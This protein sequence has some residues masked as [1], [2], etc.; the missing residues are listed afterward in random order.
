MDTKQLDEKLLRDEIITNHN[1]NMF[2]EAGAGA[3][4]T[5]LIVKKVANMLKDG[6]KPEEI[7]VITFTNAAVEELQSRIIAEVRKMAKDAK[8]DVKLKEILDNIDRMNISTIHSFC[9]LLLNEQS[10][11]AGLPQNIKVMKEPENKQLK[12]DYFKQYLRTLK[13]KDWNR[14]KEYASPEADKYN[15]QY[16]LFQ[17]YET[18][19]DLPTE[20]EIIIPPMTEKDEQERQLLEIQ[21]KIRDFLLGN[22]E[23]GIKGFA[24]E[25]KESVNDCL[26]PNKSKPNVVKTYAEL[27][28]IA[29]E[30]VGVKKE[31]I[32]IGKAVLN[33]E[34]IK[35]LS[36]LETEDGKKREDVDCVEVWAEIP[37]SNL[38]FVK[39]H[40]DPEYFDVDA[41]SEES[42]KV[43]DALQAL[44]NDIKEKYDIEGIH[45]IDELKD[46]FR[47]EVYYGILIEYA[48]KAKEDFWKNCPP[49][50]ISND[51]LL[52]MARDMICNND[53]IC[54]YFREKYKILFVDEF[55]DTDHVQAE[56][57][58][59]LASEPDPEN[60]EYIRLRDGALF[61]VGDPKQ[62]IYRFRG[63]EPENY[64]YI[65]NKMAGLKNA[66]IYELKYNFR[67][68]ISIINWVNGKFGQ[69]N[70]GTPIV[71]KNYNFLLMEKPP[72]EED[73]Q[74]QLT[75][76]NIL[77]GI[78]YHRSPDR[79]RTKG[80]S[81]KPIY[82]S[83]QEDVD[84]V[85]NL[86]LKLIG[87]GESEEK[88]SYKLYDDEIKSVRDIRC[89]DILLIS[90]ETK[91]MRR[92]VEAL[93]QYDIPVRLEGA[94]KINEDLVINTYLRIYKYLIEN[95]ERS[96]MGAMEA[97]R[98][99]MPEEEYDEQFKQMAK[100]I[101]ARLVEQSKDMTDYGKARYLEKQLSVL[102]TK[103]CAIAGIDV[104]TQQT[105]IRQMLEMIC[106]MEPTVGP[107]I[108]KR[109]EEY[110]K[111]RIER[112]LSLEQKADAVR[113]INLH[114]TK[115]LEGNIVILLDRRS[116]ALDK[117]VMYRQGKKIWLGINTWP[118]KQV[119][120]EQREQFEEESQAEF[121]RLE[122]VMATRAKQA[123][124]FMDVLEEKGLFA[125]DADGTW[126]SYEIEQDGVSLEEATKFTGLE[127]RKPQVEEN[128]Y[129]KIQEE[130]VVSDIGNIETCSEVNYI[131]VSPSGKEKTSETK[132][133]VIK[134]AIQ[135]IKQGEIAKP[136]V[137]SSLT[138]PTG[139]IM[140]NVLHRTME[141]FVNRFTPKMD[142]EQ[143]EEMISYCV[144]QAAVENKED[145]EKDSNS[146]QAQY[147]QFVMA[148]GKAYY[149]WFCQE[150]KMLLSQEYRTFTELPFQYSYEEN[151]RQIWVNGTADLVIQQGDEFILID[152][153]SDT[154]YLVPEKEMHIAL[155][156]RYE[157]QL[158]LY[159][160]VLK[161]IFKADPKKIRKMIISFSQK[162]ENGN[163]YAGEEIR[164]R[165]TE[166]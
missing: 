154:D 80:K 59:R 52:Q 68:D 101:L 8:G 164:V 117:H 140:G 98:M 123:L 109:M 49:N 45:V 40:A 16:E 81:K 48:Q 134:L 130:S 33:L 93:H 157:S 54:Q 55:Q 34:L 25:Y 53:E 26:L 150:F 69:L 76:K 160:N 30:K 72:T 31:S 155:K 95:T 84:S 27:K 153:K 146:G 158:N 129:Y 103:D 56:L 43:K 9:S 35:A 161:T 28:K 111:E 58:Y 46:R 71:D 138:R 62:S 137:S 79:G 67:S 36:K 159:E 77:K 11:L 63:A 122:Y 139:N 165:V 125:P 142:R 110:I 20:T 51:R 151:D 100:K 41:F 3:G 4:K 85:V 163:L 135:Q 136:A 132:A 94:I 108:I 1:L 2:V 73:K 147:E 82:P 12:S 96:K 19:C 116:K 133:K 13:K 32:E 75:D 6:I 89:S 131:K 144:K 57:I 83:Q 17:F 44:R 90:G 118:T 39:T 22:P 14:L 24:E 18:M 102:F 143:V 65:K 37:K 124:I 7:V 15:I 23:K 70:A 127:K 50:R 97:L 115:G 10:V 121:R 78:Y 141:L 60:K 92:Y 29:E 119:L 86:I 99:S 120:K 61:V 91:N 88:E 162:D 128:E 42:A 114:K 105:H 21:E 5:S 145:I 156:E 64:F 166:I 38:G 152:Y 148:C 66:K 87:K 113:F 106:S 74:D 149:E 107:E 126:Y 104:K 112:E 47:K